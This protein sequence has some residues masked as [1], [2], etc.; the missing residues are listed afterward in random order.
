VISQTKFRSYRKP[1]DTKPAGLSKREFMQQ[2]A[3]SRA[4]EVPANL[5]GAAAAQAALEAWETIEGNCK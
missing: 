2:Y 5:N 1:V 4:A 3:L